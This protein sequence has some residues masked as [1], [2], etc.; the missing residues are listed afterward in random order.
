MSLINTIRNI[1]SG[2]AHPASPAYTWENTGYGLLFSLPEG[3]GKTPIFE[4]SHAAY[5]YTILQMLLEADEAVQDK[6]GIH[7]GNETLCRLDEASREILGLPKPWPGS[8]ELEVHGIS[9]NPDF[10]L[11]LRLL[12]ERGAEKFPAKMSGPF[13]QADGKLYLPNAA[14]WR[15]LHAVDEHSKLTFGERTEAANLKAILAL[16]NARKNG[17]S[18]NLRHFNDLEVA[19]AEHVGVSVAE[20]DDGSIRLVPAFGLGISPDAKE[21][22]PEAIEAR[23]GQLEGKADT[24]VLRVDKKLVL[25]DEKRLK[26]VQEIL[27]SRVISAKNKHQFF[28]TPSAFLDASLVDLDMGFSMR[29]K[30]VTVFQ[31][32]YFGYSENDSLTWFEE[33]GQ[34]PPQII[35]L[36]G[37]RPLLE[38]EKELDDLRN[39]GLEALKE[40][41]WSVDFKD[42]TIQLPE[43][44]E[45]FEQD[46]ARLREKLLKKQE[47]LEK[48]DGEG[49]DTGNKPQ[50]QVVDIWLNDGEADWGKTLPKQMPF[51]PYMEPLPTG[52]WHYTAES[53]QEAGIRWLLG[54]MKNMFQRLEHTD[55]D[56]CGGL[57]ADDMGLGKTF[58]VLASL[59]VYRDL[60]QKAGKDKPVL[61]IMPVVLLE[62]W[63]KE[64]EKVFKASPFEKDIVVLQRD[65]ELQRFR[66]TGAGRETGAQTGTD[67]A[68]E[69]HIRYSLKIGSEFGPDRLDL[70][71]RLVLTNYNTL[72]D[73]QFSLCQVDW[74]CVIFDEAQDIKNPNTIKA[75]AAKGLKADFRLAVTGTPVENSLADFW[76][77]YDTVKPG[78]L[79]AFQ[80]FRKHYISPIKTAEPGE[81]DNRRLELGR[82]LRQRV[83]PFMLRRTKEDELSGL[84]FKIVHDGNDGMNDSTK[85]CAMMSGEQLDAYNE[86][87][88]TVVAAK[89]SG[90]GSRVRQVLLPSLQKLQRVSL[91]PALKDGEPAPG[92]NRKEAEAELKRSAKLELL[93]TILEEIKT[94]G[95]KAILFVIT[96]SLQRFLAHTLGM[97]YGQHIDIINGDTKSVAGASGRGEASRMEL[98]RKFEE[99][100]G[101][102]IIIM[103]P[104]AAGV[105]LTV[106]GANNV[107]H[108]E[109][110]WNPAKEAQATDRVYRIG[111]TKDVHVYIP[112]LK[113]PAKKSFDENLSELL[114]RKL[115][116]RDAVVTTS[117]V[118]AE[119]FDTK[120]LFGTDLSGDEP[121][122]PDCLPGLSW[123]NFEALTA[124]LA[125]KEFGGQAY[126]TPQSGDHGADVVLMDVSNGPDLIIQC[127]TSQKAFGESNAA[128]EAHSA[129]AEY[130]KRLRSETLPILAVNAPS[131]EANVRE[132]AKTLDVKIWDRPFLEELLKKHRIRYRELGNLLAQP[133]LA[134]L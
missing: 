3:S 68:S 66:R 62:N 107:I 56:S 105:G 101:F 132:R 18:I 78:L 10:S 122:H 29:V 16:E 116:I 75:R 61:A 123:E 120:D 102:H 92:E 65:A 39:R 126:L 81:R 110:H 71:G 5:Q 32:A 85:Y 106:V 63:K 82:E 38:N 111:Q 129:R 119:D 8:F 64:V 15:A 40:P 77:I 7:V 41:R 127:K 25:L 59:G 47:N 49:T 60:A 11:A 118:R 2:H 42:K 46:I 54:L 112:V 99:K 73:Y 113:H 37:C 93:L 76:S 114:G 95:E 74:G 70:P 96:K 13:I 109:R 108:L 84:P 128:A 90:D 72:A 21:L 86:V 53:Y 134:R 50:P 94:R 30:G 45:E 125:Q 103:S 35:P 51:P 131:V 115:D 1:F 100:E 69:K 121:I 31:K 67:N 52:K 19:E 12:P 83:G 33:N 133:R 91:H 28:K 130:G 104:L 20:N 79:G 27:S 124:L 89:Q 22:S 55:N 98:I 26:A 36:E 48:P 23:L 24:A 14:Q 43:T 80:D 87:I 9:P 57:L 4:E 6:R 58:M 117:E 34:E 44:E 88:A 17:M 97:M